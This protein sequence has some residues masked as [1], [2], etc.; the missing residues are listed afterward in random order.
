MTLTEAK[1]IA[2]EEIARCA[3]IAVARYAYR[4]EPRV[5][6]NV[7]GLCAGKANGRLV[8]IRM[9]PQLAEQGERAVRETAA[10]EYAHLVAYARAV[11]L[12]GRAPSPHGREW[13]SI[14][15]AFGHAPERC[16]SFA[17]KR[18]R[19][20]RMTDF[21]CGCGAPHSFGPVRAG[22]ALARHATTGRTGFLCGICRGLL[23][24][25]N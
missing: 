3:A 13:Q 20:V 16:H 23:T 22:R 24:P 19:Q 11:A 10:H 12:G 4:G 5:D 7:R 9:N 8:H 21:S 14:M 1:A 6:W 17:F 25:K 15:R 2:A 18:A